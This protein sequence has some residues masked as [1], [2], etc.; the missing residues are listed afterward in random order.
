MNLRSSLLVIALTTTITV[1]AALF[2]N[3]PV[4]GY[5]QSLANL[6][7][8]GYH[9]IDE[10][11]FEDGLWHAE[12]TRADGRRVDVVITPDTGAVLDPLQITTPVLVEAVLATVSGAGYTDVRDLE[13]DGA[14][15]EVDAR[16]ANGRA[17]ELFVSAADGRIL[18]VQAT[19]HDHDD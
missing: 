10:L 1:P 15:Y 7:A 4:I 12:V 19:G 5:E 17:V 8:A 18:S 16:D 13:R 9:N 14:L 11:E 3:T 6:S 2:A